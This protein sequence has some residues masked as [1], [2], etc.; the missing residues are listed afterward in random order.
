MLQGCRAVT[1]LSRGDFDVR[2]DYFK[3]IRLGF[4]PFRIFFD[5]FFYCFSFFTGLS[6]LLWAALAAHVVITRRM[7][8]LV[9]IRGRAG[10]E[11]LG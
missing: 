5:L 10:L 11:H 6:I 2:I 3:R 7:F 8:F 4:R 9:F 1:R